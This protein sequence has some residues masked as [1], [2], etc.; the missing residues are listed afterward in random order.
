MIIAGHKIAKRLGYDYSIVLG[1]ENYYPKHG[2]VCADT[3][4]I[5]PPFEVPNENFM[6]YKL[7]E[8]ISNITGVVKYAKVFGID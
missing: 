1:S 3:Y 4:G 6:A 8:N 7:N 5:Y 2:Y